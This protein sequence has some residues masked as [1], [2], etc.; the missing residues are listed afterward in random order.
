MKPAPFLFNLTSS[1]CPYTF[2]WVYVIHVFFFIHVG[3]KRWLDVPQDMKLIEELSEL[4]YL[5]KG[6]CF[7][8]YG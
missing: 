2:G 8:M 3:P 7:S 6:L 5:D 1:E 4:V